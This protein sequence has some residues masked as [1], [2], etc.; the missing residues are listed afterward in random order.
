M[1]ENETFRVWVEAPGWKGSFEL[2]QTCFEEL[3]AFLTRQA[4]SGN[5]TTVTHPLPN[6]APG[7][8][9]A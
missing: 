1:E 9:L 2:P 5:K 8:Q 6:A 3:T 7:L 4:V